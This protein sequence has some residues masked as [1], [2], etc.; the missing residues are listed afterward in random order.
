MLNNLLY[1]NILNQIQVAKTDT[2]LQT[3]SNAIR[4]ENLE[5]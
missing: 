2:R 3:W 4:T 5:M 1:I